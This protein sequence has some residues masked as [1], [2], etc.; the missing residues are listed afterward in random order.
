MATRYREVTAATRTALR[1][2]GAAMADHP[3]FVAV[4]ERSL[5]KSEAAGL[6]ERRERLLAGARGRVL[7]IGAGTGVNLGHYPASGVSGLVALEPDG[8]MRRRLLPRLAS[9]GI[10]FEVEQAGIDDARFEDGSFDTIVSTLVLCTVPD[11]DSAAHQ[12]RRWLAPDGQLL[13]LEHVHS[14]GL[15][16]RAQQVVNP[17]WRLLV[18]GCHLNRDTLAALRRAGLFVT[19]CERFPLPAGGPLLTSCV[20]GIARPGTA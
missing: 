6:A 13:F 12:I 11:L 8:A 5:E 18:G 19:D 16:G 15:R 9:S 17:L 1:Y 10:S 3:L 14:A 7:E 2:G 20:Q 4:Y